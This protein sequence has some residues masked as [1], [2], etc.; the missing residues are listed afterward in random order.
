MRDDTFEEG[1]TTEEMAEAYRL[2]DGRMPDEEA[3]A[4]VASL[5]THTRRRL[6]VVDALALG[7][8]ARFATDDDSEYDIDPEVCRQVK[9]FLPLFVRGGVSAAQR[10]D[11]ESHLTWCD[12]CTVAL[13]DAQ[14]AVMNPSRRR[15]P[16]HH[17]AT[18]GVIAAISVAGG[19]HAKGAWSPSPPAVAAPQEEPVTSRSLVFKT[20]A[21][22]SSYSNIS[23]RSKN[24]AE[25]GAAAQL[26]LQRYDPVKMNSPLMHHQARADLRMCL[27]IVGRAAHKG[28]APKGSKDFATDMLRHPDP[29]V[30][31]ESGVWYKFVVPNYKSDPELVALVQASRHATSGPKLPKPE[32][33]D[34]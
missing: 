24:A 10:R 26:V 8:A 34:L 3:K 12:D 32:D 20:N 11:V 7:V 15:V 4:Y 14:G 31:Q 9:E 2:I 21:E 1:P 6:A 27:A 5:K 28:T 13:A 33:S 18:A 17:L 16:W 19:W 29:K 23:M 25:L 30:R 22:R